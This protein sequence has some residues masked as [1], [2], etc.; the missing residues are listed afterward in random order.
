MPFAQSLNVIY[1]SRIWKYPRALDRKGWIR[2][3]RPRYSLDFAEE[4][5]S[6]QIWEVSRNG[7]R[8]TQ[9]HLTEL[10]RAAGDAD[11]FNAT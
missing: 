9:L 8:Q 2:R 10:P 11:K 1:I 3:R 4:L 5:S 6:G 7:N